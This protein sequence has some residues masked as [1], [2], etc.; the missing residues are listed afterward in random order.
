MKSI[1]MEEVKRI[2]NVL[3]YY[4][5]DT[6]QFSVTGCKGCI[7]DVQKIKKRTQVKSQHFQPKVLL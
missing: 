2:S 7:C 6:K 5:D 1:S 3:Q 4:P